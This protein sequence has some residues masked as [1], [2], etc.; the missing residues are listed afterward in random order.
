MVHRNTRHS[1]YQRA[2]AQNSAVRFRPLQT[3]RES[4]HPRA[5]SYGTRRRNG[6]LGMNAGTDS[7]TASNGPAPHNRTLNPPG[8]TPVLAATKTTGGSVVPSKH[9]TLSYAETANFVPSRLHR[10]HAQGKVENTRMPAGQNL[11]ETTQRY[12]KAEPTAPQRVGK[13]GDGRQSH[14]TALSRNVINTPP[15][16]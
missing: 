2:S 1:P 6:S 12:T 7:M 8:P 10:F 13:G 15:L 3:L 11:W 9:G 5:P 16:G 14:G 4:R